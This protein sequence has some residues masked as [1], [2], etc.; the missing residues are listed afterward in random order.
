MRSVLRP[1]HDNAGQFSGLKT[2]VFVALLVPG[3]WTVTFYSM[4]ELGARPLNTAIHQFGLWAFR[5]L[6]ISLAVTPLRQ[7]L[8]WPRLAL[9]RRMIG[10]AA[11]AYGAVHLLLYVGDQGFDL[12]K[13]ATEIA[14]R[15]YLT[16]GFAALLAMT[17]LAATSTNRML[18][19][20]GGRRWRLLHRI[21]Y[22]IGLLAL[23]H[24]FM[25]SKADVSE[26][27]LMSGFLLW[28]MGYRALAAMQRAGRMTPLLLAPFS[29]AVGALTALGE[30]LYFWLKLGAPPELVLAAQLDFAAG[31][32]PGWVVLATGL[33]VALAAIARESWKRAPRL[34]PA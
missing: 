17:A 20:L 27:L 23:V 33:A 7:A 28:L 32:R 16:I 22:P 11:F 9:V 6:L 5:L 4:G 1:F 34:R 21:A 18:G 10:V 2:A 15:I 24:F 29:I 12:A 8:H 26:P 19:R 25:Q 31:V 30:A 13:V 14:I 3:M